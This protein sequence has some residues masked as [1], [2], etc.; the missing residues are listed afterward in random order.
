MTTI[1]EDRLPYRKVVPGANDLE[2]AYPELMARWDYEKN[3]AS[4]LRPSEIRPKVRRSAWWRCGHE[5]SWQATV[6]GVVLYGKAVCPYCSGRRAWPGYN[7]LATLRPE[8]LAYWDYCANDG[9]GLQPDRELTTSHDVAWWI[10]R[11]CGGGYRR[12]VRAQCKSIGGLMC[13]D[14]FSKTRRRSTGEKQLADWLRANCKH[15]VVDDDHSLLGKREID[16]YV[17]GLSLGFEY[18]GTYW[19]STARSAAGREKVEAGLADKSKHALKWMDCRAKGV[20][21]IYVW[22]C[23]WI[24]SGGTGDRLR[25]ELK[26]VIEAAGGSGLRAV[27]D[28]S[29]KSVA[30]SVGG[31]T[32]VFP[33]Q[34]DYET[35]SAAAWLLRHVDGLQETIGGPQERLLDDSLRFM[36]GDSPASRMEARAVAYDSGGSR[37]SIAPEQA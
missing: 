1:D 34:V 21:L 20:D 25:A 4:G 8:L 26:M 16:C 15:A 28:S 35:G 5:H 9:A 24:D 27:V 2:T 29:E 3:E 37:F 31:P 23:D 6:K 19:H 33:L 14:C 22:E 11:L 36:D 30:M 12:A 18:N 10:C 7:D 32:L 13:P 17:P